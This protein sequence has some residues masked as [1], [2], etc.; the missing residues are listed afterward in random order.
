MGS[1]PEN[2]DPIGDF[3]RLLQRVA[4]EDDRNLF[5]AQT[6]DQ[7]EEIVLLLR[8]QSGGRLVEYDDLR[9][10][11]NRS[12]DLD[13]LPLGGAERLDDRRRI[14]GKIQRLKQLLRLDIRS[15]QAIEKLLVAQIEILRD[16]QRGDEARLLID[17]GDPM[18]PRVCGAANLDPFAFEAE[19]AL[20]GRNRAGEDLDQ[21]RLAR[22]V[23]AQQG[24]HFAAPQI[25]VDVLQRGD[26]AIFLGDVS[27][28]QERRFRL[29]RDRHDASPS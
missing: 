12:R 10:E 3:E 18:P 5:L 23:L 14:D 22:A 25:E 8:S 13:H 16:G 29:R 21:R 1:V 24:V 19:L 20:G 17:H 27:H 7:R 6:I 28:R 2:G 4:D 15:P 9:L 11:T 26:A